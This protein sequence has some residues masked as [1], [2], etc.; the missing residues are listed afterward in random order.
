[1]V[2]TDDPCCCSWDLGRSS[3][4]G[5]MA[6]VVGV[7]TGARGE[8]D[9][10]DVVCCSVLLVVTSHWRSL[11]RSSS[12]LATLLDR[13]EHESCRLSSPSIICGYACGAV[14]RLSVDW[15]LLKQLFPLVV[16]L[17]SA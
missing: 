1:M 15:L 10:A 8:E 2:A 13:L 12:V 16:L 17:G 5:N 9:G 14:R 6:A 4:V 11:L 7:G 3:V